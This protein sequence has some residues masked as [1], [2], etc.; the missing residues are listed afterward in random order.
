MWRWWLRGVV[1]TQLLVT[2]SQI[3][4]PPI[5]GSNSC[6]K[7]LEGKVRKLERLLSQLKSGIKRN[8]FCYANEEEQEKLIL[9]TLMVSWRKEWVLKCPRS[10]I[11]PWPPISSSV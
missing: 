1:V 7:S 3:I 11:S 9:I 5:G 2:E 10:P 8:A 4:N 6:S